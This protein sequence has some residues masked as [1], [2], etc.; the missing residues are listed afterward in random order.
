[1]GRSIRGHGEVSGDSKAAGAFSQ[2]H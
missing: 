2:Q 1:V